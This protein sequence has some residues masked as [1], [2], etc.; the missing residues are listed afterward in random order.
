LTAKR[1][2]LFQF[3]LGNP[4]WLA[5][6]ELNY[7]RPTL[8]L[9]VLLFLVMPLPCTS[10]ASKTESKISSCFIGL[11][12]V[13]GHLNIDPY[14][15]PLALIEGKQTLVPKEIV[16]WFEQNN[17]IATYQLWQDS[18]DCIGDLTG[19]RPKLCHAAGAPIPK[20]QMCENKEASISYMAMHKHLIQSRKALWPSQ[21]GAFSAW[22]KFPLL[23]DVYPQPEETLFN[24]WPDEVADH[25]RLI[26]RI[27]MMSHTELLFRW[28]TEKDFIHW[29]MCGSE[30]QGLVAN[31]LI[32][33]ME[34][35]ASPQNRLN[36]QHAIFWKNII[37]L[38]RAWNRYRKRIGQTQ[39]QPELQAKVIKQ[40]QVFEYWQ[41]QSIGHSQVTQ[42]KIDTTNFSSRTKTIGQQ[43]RFIGEIIELKSSDH[44]QVFIHFKPTLMGVAPVWLSSKKHF[45]IESFTI[46]EHYVVSGEVIKT[47]KILENLLNHSPT[48]ILAKSIQTPK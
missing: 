43:L 4:F 27:G 3:K 33:A 5:G 6:F 40:C 16:S 14:T 17:W 30:N 10:Y 47:P 42:S 44:N 46:G 37:W 1:F 24:A 48:L 45:S 2:I 32:E 12:P 35:N 20:T 23:P 21:D 31:S 15:E 38:D 18:L 8:W 26:N 36:L 13:A 19:S 11:N 9:C 25:G 34:T 22:E 39:H 7:A 28:P 29:L 41:G